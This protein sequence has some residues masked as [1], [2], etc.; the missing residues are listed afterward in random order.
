MRSLLVF[1]SSGHF[2]QFGWT[3]KL[4]P[5]HLN[6]FDSRLIVSSV[7]FVLHSTSRLLPLRL[8]SFSLPFLQI[9]LLSSCIILVGQL[10]WVAGACRN[11]AL[12]SGQTFQSNV[13]RQQFA[14]QTC[15][16]PTRS[17]IPFSLRIKNSPGIY[18]FNQP[19]IFALS[20]HFPK[21]CTLEKPLVS[22][23]HLLHSSRW[24]KFFFLF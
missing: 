22:G 12:T 20:I 15:F 16:N 23:S 21:Q 19:I 11:S 13:T 2:T 10:T 4:V 6:K 5:F 7:T 17:I 14:N 9:L 3:S 1:C 8:R 18:F 24:W